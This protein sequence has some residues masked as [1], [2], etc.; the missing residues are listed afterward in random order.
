MKH[1]YSLSPNHFSDL[2]KQEFF[3][4]MMPTRGLPRPTRPAGLNGPVSVLPIPT[5][6]MMATIPTSIDWRQHN[7]V[8]RVKD[9][10]VC[11]SCW[12][13]GTIG[14]L[15]GQWAVKY[16]KLFS[17]SEQQIVDCSWET[18][19]QGNSGCDGG[20]EHLHL[21]GCGTMEESQTSM[22]IHISW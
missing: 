8:T 5:P 15:E 6:E 17:L 22:N 13:F 14:S 2:K 18:W 9:Q 10:G 11:G 12:T 1:G 3:D 21:I 4:I 19:P 16:K 7:A 20:F